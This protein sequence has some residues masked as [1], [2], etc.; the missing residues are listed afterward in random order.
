[1]V[2]TNLQL[3]IPVVSRLPVVF[4]FSRMRKG[5]GWEGRGISKQLPRG[6]PSLIPQVSQPLSWDSE[7]VSPQ[8][9]RIRSIM[10]FL[11]TSFWSFEQWVLATLGCLM[12]TVRS[13]LC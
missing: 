1:L 13:H 12:G 5:G 10:A 9:D 6:S 4:L 2:G 11:V 8:L 3:E 7:M